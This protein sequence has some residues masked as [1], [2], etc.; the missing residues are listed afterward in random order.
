MPRVVG[1]NQIL[2]VFLAY[3]RSKVAQWHEEAAS[4]YRLS[5]MVAFPCIDQHAQ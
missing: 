4:H 5:L 1:F 3:A 2:A